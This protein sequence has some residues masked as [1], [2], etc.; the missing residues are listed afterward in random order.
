MIVSLG[1]GLAKKNNIEI[2]K[3][4]IDL[5]GMSLPESDLSGEK[6]QNAKTG[7]WR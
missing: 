4:S 2:G 6:C 3:G 5:E 7:R 1:F